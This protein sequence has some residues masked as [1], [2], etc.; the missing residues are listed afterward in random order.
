M[1]VPARPTAKQ[2]NERSTVTGTL[3]EHGGVILQKGPFGGVFMRAGCVP[4]T[5]WHR[6]WETLKQ[7][8]DHFVKQEKKRLEE[9]D[10]ARA[11]GGK[12]KPYVCKGIYICVS[13]GSM[14]AIDFKWLSRQGF[15]FHH[16]RKAGHGTFPDDPSSPEP[17]RPPAGG[18][19]SVHGGTKKV[20]VT[21]PTD[22][23]H[24]N[25]EFVYYCWPGRPEHDRHPSYATSIEG[26]TGM[27]LS[28]DET[29]VLLVWERGSWSTP[30]GAVEPGE[31]KLD[32]LAREMGEE[33]NLKLDLVGWGA[34]YL[35]GWQ[36]SKA[37]DNLIND[38]FSSFLVKAADDSFQ[39]DESEITDADWFEW[40][41]MLDTWRDAGK[42]K[43][44]DKGNKLKHFEMDVGKP[45]A[46][47]DKKAENM[48]RVRLN[49]LEWLDQWQDKRTIKCEYIVGK[50]Q[51]GEPAS[52]VKI[53]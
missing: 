2:I 40:R 9:N 38:N 26:V 12:D 33:V 22:D 43:T 25:A 20:V 39:V 36:Q 50:P 45:E 34:E 31:N 27:A 47:S 21:K 41:H 35:G 13:Q 32:A 52:K 14:Q 6:L 37:R 17:I 11:K 4:R 23:N 53:G 42:P 46:P 3:S 29:R 18:N 15:R 24:D 16:Y 28:S 30:G 19:G 10:E 8:T 7:Y 48:N 49:V 51:A 44:D 1:L 5:P